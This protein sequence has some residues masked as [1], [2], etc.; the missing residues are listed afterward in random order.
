MASPE[1]IGSEWLIRL[2]RATAKLRIEEEGQLDDADVLI[3]IAKGDFAE[4]V[5]QL[6]LLSRALAEHDAAV[7]GEMVEAQ[8]TER[9]V[10][11]NEIIQWVREIRQRREARQGRLPWYIAVMRIMPKRMRDRVISA[12]LARLV[13]EARRQG[14]FTKD[15]LDA[16][17]AAMK[18]EKRR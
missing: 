12:V 17:R 5:L 9:R 18:E 15:D 10:T 16:F 1:E 11:D 13:R 4:L 7:A 8:M 2:G 3:P 6:S 14:F